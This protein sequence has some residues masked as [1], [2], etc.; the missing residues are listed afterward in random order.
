MS[1]FFLLFQSYT[2]LWK[3]ASYE[4]KSLIDW[5]SI[6]NSNNGYRDD[7]LVMGQAALELLYNWYIV[8][9]KGLLKG[10][11]A[12]NIDAS[13]KIR[14]LLNEIRLNTTCPP[15]LNRVQ[16]MIDDKDLKLKD[17]IDVIVEIRNA[18]IHSNLHKRTK[19][20]KIIGE[21]K[22]QVLNLTAYYLELAILFTFGY[23]GTYVNRLSSKNLEVEAI[24]NVPWIAI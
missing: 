8:E 3:G 23:S 2:K 18:I 6:V 14:L 4:I 12:R 16:E 24:E 9:Q 22:Y 19:I 21:A 7:K 17:A 10:D 20:S 13:N 1:S 15:T 5:Y 11:D